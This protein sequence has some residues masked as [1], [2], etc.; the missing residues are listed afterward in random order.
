MANA[1]DGHGDGLL[2]QVHTGQGLRKDPAVGPRGSGDE[3]PAGFFK[4]R[5]LAC[6]VPLSARVSQGMQK[7]TAGLPQA[8]ATLSAGSLTQAVVVHRDTA[9]RPGCCH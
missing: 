8:T 5:G 3:R 1:A 2:K 9:R 7:G 6:V 4:Q